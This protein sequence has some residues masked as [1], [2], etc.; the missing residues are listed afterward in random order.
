VQI[1]PKAVILLEYEPILGEYTQVGESWKPD[2]LEIPN[3]AHIS[4]DI[5][6]ASVNPSQFV[7]ALTRRILVLLNLTDDNKFQVVK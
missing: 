2:Q 4:H 1:T 3:R 7:L 6:A 5:V